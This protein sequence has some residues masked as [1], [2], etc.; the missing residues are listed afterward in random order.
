MKN[1]HLRNSQQNR[2]IS[3]KRPRYNV[4]R[5]KPVKVSSLQIKDRPKIEIV[6]SS[7]QLKEISWLLKSYEIAKPG[8][9]RCYFRLN[10]RRRKLLNDVLV[11]SGCDSFMCGTI[12]DTKDWSH[13]LHAIWH[14]I[15][16]RPLCK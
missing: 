8:W 6:I 5:P 15:N 14:A 3:S 12:T 10:Q 7:Q 1:S 13:D 9:L 2:S 11:E 16:E 4:N